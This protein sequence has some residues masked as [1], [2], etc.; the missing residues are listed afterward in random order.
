MQNGSRIWSFGR[1]IGCTILSARDAAYGAED[2]AEADVPQC[3]DGDGF[4]PM[5]ITDRFVYI[6]MPKTGGTF[7]ERVLSRLL[8]DEDGLYFDTSRTDHQAVLGS[9]T[10]HESVRQIPAVHKA[11]KIL[12]TV[13][14]PYDHYVS[15]YEFGWWKSHPTDTFDERKMRSLFPHYPEIT[16]REYMESVFKL[17]LLDS[18]YVDSGTRSR[19]ENANC[20]P[21]TLDYIRFLFPDPDRIIGNLPHY[22]EGNAYLEELPDIQFLRTDHLNRELHDFLLTLGYAPEHLDFILELGK[23]VPVGSTRPDDS[24]W[25]G[26]YSAELKDLVRQKERWLFS[27]FPEFDR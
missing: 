25:E 5:V 1:D 4:L 19:L 21:L 8:S 24:D 20:G 2:I 12:F 10:K 27:A 6:H 18:A 14:N 22:L 26:Y 13:R 7:V 17:E 16:F 11:R 3:A 9:E 15:F 23:I